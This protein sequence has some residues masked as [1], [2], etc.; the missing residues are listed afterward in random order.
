M[1]NE[2]DIIKKAKQKFP[3]KQW[4][5]VKVKKDAFAPYESFFK[6]IVK[7]SKNPKLNHTK[8]LLHIHDTTIT[9][10]SRQFPMDPIRLELDNKLWVELYCVFKFIK[11]A[12]TFELIRDKDDDPI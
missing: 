8:Y 10:R 1:I 9:I 5:Y 11:T 12:D 3:K 4:I 6:K 7:D 2:K